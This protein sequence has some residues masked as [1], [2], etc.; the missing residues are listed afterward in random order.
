MR[1]GWWIGVFLA[2]LAALLLPLILFARA[3]GAEVPPVQ[4]L[5]VVLAASVICQALHREPLPR[6]VGP[7]DRRWLREFLLGGLGG[8]LLM[9]VPALV[10]GIF[11]VVSWRSGAGGVAALWAEV[12]LLAAAAATEE[13]L[14]RGFLFRRLLEGLGTWPAQLLMAALFLL[15]HSDALRGLGSLA[16]LA[17]ANIF[18]ASILFGL[19]YLRTRSLAMPLGLHLMANVTQGPVLGFG[20]SGHEGASLLV[21]TPSGAPDWL[22]GGT[23]GLEA[24]LPGLV[25]VVALALLLQGWRGYRAG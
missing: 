16:L 21:P 3:S 25:C 2:V 9:A 15:T 7:I 23:F 8:L 18:L 6:L 5:A 12:G 10:L 4:Q 19:A 24:S 13:L 1:S 22:Y 14:F 20:V 11:G 17:G